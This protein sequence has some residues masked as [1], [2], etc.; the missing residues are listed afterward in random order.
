MSSEFTCK[1]AQA[2]TVARDKMM[3]S[4]SV[5]RECHTIT[6]EGKNHASANACKDACEHRMSDKERMSKISDIF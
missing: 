1:S 6:S 3:Q 2:E 4:T 5:L